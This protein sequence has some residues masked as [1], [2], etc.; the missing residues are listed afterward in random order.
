MRRPIF[1]GGTGRCGTTLV[2]DLLAESPEVRCRRES[3]VRVHT[4]PGGLLDL[5]DALGPRWTPY[6][7]DAAIERFVSYL[8]AFA[9]PLERE[10]AEKLLEDVLT[11]IGLPSWP[12]SITFRP[13]YRRGNGMN[14]PVIEFGWERGTSHRDRAE[15]ARTAIRY[16]FDNLFPEGG[17]FVVEA[18]PDNAL[19]ILQ[20][21]ELWPEAKVVHVVRDPLDVV[22][23]M[24]TIAN[25]RSGGHPYWPQDF[26]AIVL[27]VRDT[28]EKIADVATW[29]YEVYLRDLVHTPEEALGSLFRRL[30]VE[31]PDEE[32][33]LAKIDQ[34]AAHEGRWRDDL[35][36]GE[37][38]RAREALVEIR[39]FFGFEEEGE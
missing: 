37:A 39:D 35:S 27:H 9:D 10:E 13:K 19:S 32:V 21:E 8:E 28:L 29:T 15:L 6:R 20:F 36:E 4:D 1:V 11:E 24:W 2:H 17:R 34:D 18:T 31:P 7:A 3:E 22:A 14:V 26:G 38:L 23:S 33:L 12:R 25:S 5:Y 30:G 16:G